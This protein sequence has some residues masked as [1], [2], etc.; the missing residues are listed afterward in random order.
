MLKTLHIETGRHLYGGALQ[1][2]SLVRGLQSRGHRAVVLCPRG[3]GVEKEL[4]ADAPVVGVPFAGDADLLFVARAVRAIRAEKPDVVHLHSRRGADIFGGAAARIC[5]VPAVVLSRRVDDPISLGILNRL[6]FGPLCDRVIAISDGI[7][8]EL[9]RAGVPAPKVEMVR[10]CVDVCQYRAPRDR[11]WFGEEFGVP[12]DAAV[13]GVIAQLIERKGHDYLLRAMPAI[14][15]RFPE[16]RTVFFGQGPRRAQL[17]ESAR[18][19]EVED[20]IV[21]AGFRPDLPRVLPNLDLVVHPATME[22]LGVSLLQTAAAGVPIVASAVGG[23]PEI[24]IDGETGLLVPPRDSD[25]IAAAA[26]RVL[27]DR[28]SA[29]RMARAAAAHVESAFGVD[30]MVEGNLRVY[31]ETL[32][33]KGYSGRLG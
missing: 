17:E 13:V 30:Q 33:S 6:R 12:P 22:G 31:L 1:V 16:C 10:S 19:L 11:R 23:I 24:V 20:R 26:V 3:S 15:R 9:L 27:E 29:D 14:L 2:A 18:E 4:S 8:G 32:E 21:F 28:E 25:A 7:R 5:R